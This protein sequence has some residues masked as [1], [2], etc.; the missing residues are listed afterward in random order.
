VKNII[1]AA[2]LGA[3]VLFGTALP[4]VSKGFHAETHAHQLGTVGLYG[5]LVLLTVWVVVSLVKAKSE[6]AQAA[7][8]PARRPAQSFGQYGRRS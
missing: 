7:N 3:D 5:G 6:R 1:G 4:R 2:V 8:A